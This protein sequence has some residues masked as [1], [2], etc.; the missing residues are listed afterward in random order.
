LAD[1]GTETLATMQAECLSL[2][3][4][5]S[6]A[7][8]LTKLTQGLNRALEWAVKQGQWP[9]L[10]RSD[11]VGLRAPADA[12]SKTLMAGA[13]YAPLPWGCRTVQAIFL[14]SPSRQEVRQ[15]SP[16][17]LART[18]A[19][20]TTG[21]PQVYAIVG[22]TCQHT[23]LAANDTFILTG[24]AVNNDVS[25]ARV[26]YRQQTGHLGEVVSPSLN[27][28]YSTGVPSPSAATS[29]W[30]IERITVSGKWA[31]DITLARSSSPFT[32]LAKISGPFSTSAANP[33]IRAETRPLIRVS[34]TPDQAY[35]CT[36]IWKRIPRKLV[37]NDD[38]PEIPVSAALVYAATA[39]ILR[40][41]KR[42]DQANQMESKKL[43]AMGAEEAGEN[44]QG[45]FV[46]PMYGNF[47]DMT[48]I[49]Y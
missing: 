10:T 14:Q 40:T 32:E 26:W 21:A 5:P 42:F 27:G 47:L 7:L 48:G 33:M 38:M 37:K 17:E 36:V 34:P 20:T 22:E 25:T 43:E 30:P 3:G 13:A 12:D 46:A 15:V 24:D 44:M 2:L 23:E 49:N 8:L 31:G 4:K 1:L 45:G 11:E 18:Y 29:G 41:E 28:T 19:T 16:E 6:S 35:A 39:D 9:T